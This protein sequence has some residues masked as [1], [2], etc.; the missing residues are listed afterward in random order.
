[1]DMVDATRTMADMKNSAEIQRVLDFG[2][3]EGGFR[4][5]F[6]TLADMLTN[7]ECNEAAAEFVRNKIR[8]IVRDE[9]T[10]ELLCPFHTIL[11]KRPP[12]GHFYYEAFNRDSVTLVD[13]KNDP[14]QAIT[15]TGLR[16]GSS[17]YDFDLIIFAVST[18]KHYG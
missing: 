3:E 15:P 1:M 14:I 8:S 12:L 5:I 17:E 9:K 2:W 11:S 16:T 4:F 6:E 13:I 10:A 18:L 7:V